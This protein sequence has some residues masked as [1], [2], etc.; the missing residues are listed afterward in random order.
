MKI[1][2]KWNKVTPFSKYLAMLLFI[3]LPFAGFYIGTEYGKQLGI[4][5]TVDTLIVPPVT[6]SIPPVTQTETQNQMQAQTQEE[7]TL[8]GVISA[9]DTGCSHDAVCKVK[10]GNYWVITNL[11]GDPTAEMTRA[12]GPHGTMTVNGVR[13]GAVSSDMVGKTATVFAKLVGNNTLTLY[14]SATY[15]LHIQ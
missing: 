12:R 2:K 4:S 7:M 10:I 8:T 11:G 1:S 15:Y 13:T 9:V 14:G 5:T 6:V 3:T